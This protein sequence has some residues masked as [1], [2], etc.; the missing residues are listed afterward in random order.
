MLKRAA[1]T[2]CAAPARLAPFH[3]A[4][5]VHDLSAARAFYGGVLGCAEGRSSK[6]WADFNMAGHQLV[7]HWAGNEYRGADHFNDVDH[8]MV[9]VP[10]FGLCLDVPTFHA[11]AAALKAADVK[12]IVEPH[13]RFP[14]KKGEQWTLFFKDPS[15]NNLE[16]KALIHPENLFAKYFVD[17]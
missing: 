5:P 17:E 11:F 7:V 6:T 4:I 3:I 16:M 9:P 15:G 10:H 14:G 8:D 1:S 2:L 13:L 12:F